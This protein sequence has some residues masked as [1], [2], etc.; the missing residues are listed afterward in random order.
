M[1]LVLFNGCSDGWVVTVTQEYGIIYLG[2][3]ILLCLFN[4]DLFIADPINTTPQI[5][6]HSF[7]YHI[8]YNIFLPVITAIV[9]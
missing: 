2:N 4:K 3:I 6:S 1:D 8:Q 7:I 5:I 9:G